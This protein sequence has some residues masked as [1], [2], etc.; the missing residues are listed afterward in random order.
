MK[1][2]KYSLTEVTTQHFGETLYQIKALKDFGIVKAGDKGGYIQQISNLSTAGDAWVFGDAKVFGDAEVSGNAWVYGNAEVPG[3]AE[4]KTPLPIKD[5][6]PIDAKTGNGKLDWTLLPYSALEETVK[7]LDFGGKKYPRDSWK[8]KSGNYL[9]RYQAAA[10]R[11]LVEIIKG[12]N[13]DPES[14]LPHAAHLACNA[15]FLTDFELGETKIK[16]GY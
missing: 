16:G 9:Q 8:A 3:N 6:K 7:V 1:N 5:N 14:G 2:T 4:E 11:H 13:I 12:N 15:L 10:M